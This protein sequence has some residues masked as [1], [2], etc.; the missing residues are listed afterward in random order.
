M[1]LLFPSLFLRIC[2]S[3]HCSSHLRP[4]PES[5]ES[6]AF[7]R[8][9]SFF[10]K[11]GGR[12]VNRY[13]CKS[14][15]KS[16]ASSAWTRCYRQKKRSVNRAVLLSLGTSTNLRKTAF[17]LGINRKTVV[18]KLLFWASVGQAERQRFLR[19]TAQG[20]EKMKMT[21]IQFDEMETFEHTKCKPLSIPVVVDAKTRRILSLGVA[22][23]PASGRLAEISRNKYGVRADLRAEVA[24]SILSEVRDSLRSDVSVT[25]DQN[26]KYPGWLRAALPPGMKHR[27]VKGRKPRASGLGELKEGRFDPLFTFNHT[28]AM[29]RAGMSRLVRRTWNTTKRPDRL[30]AHL[31]LYAYFHNTELI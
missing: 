27:A 25:T 9:S 21:D 4:L 16:F 1:D 23:M 12:W 10:R 15:Q 8:I 13:R 5:R 28:A 11:D 6:G 2:P 29:K 24:V 26:P 19:E 31:E 22:S 7:V 3:S 20:G 30:L 14:C 18:R 17:C